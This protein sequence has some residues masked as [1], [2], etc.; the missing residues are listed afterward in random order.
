MVNIEEQINLID[1]IKDQKYFYSIISF[2]FSANLCLQVF[3]SETII[4]LI[5]SNINTY[6][7]LKIIVGSIIVYGLLITIL[8]P[9]VRLLCFKFIFCLPF[10]KINKRI[11]DKYK[12]KK[13]F[14]KTIDLRR[15]ALLERNEFL[16]KYI[17]DYYKQKKNVSAISIDSI[18]IL[19]LFIIDI[20]FGYSINQSLIINILTASKWH[21]LFIIEIA[22]CIVII[23][24]LLIIIYES[25]IEFWDDT[26]FFPNEEE[27][28]A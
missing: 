7:I 23:L 20:T 3:Q 18:N 26:I 25:Y 22:I 13:Y 10:I 16:L 15:K 21:I 24:I 12:E 14:S 19:I 28:E 4:L 27:K 9:F 17:K 5:S 11:M 8:I 6:Q 2:L 1:K